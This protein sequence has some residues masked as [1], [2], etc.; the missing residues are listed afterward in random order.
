M[1]ESKGDCCLCGGILALDNLYVTLCGPAQLC[2]M[3]QKNVGLQLAVSI[4]AWTV[5]MEKCKI[6]ES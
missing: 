2:K 3:Q 1:Y 5:S 6:A 4:L